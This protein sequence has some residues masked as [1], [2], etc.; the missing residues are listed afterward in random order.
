M[1]KQYGVLDPKRIDY[2][3][4][5]NLCLIAFGSLW[6]GI[7][8]ATTKTQLVAVEVLKI[9]LNA[10]TFNLMGANFLQILACSVL[11]YGGMALAV[12]LLVVSIVMKRYRAIP[13]NVAL[14]F[15]AGLVPAELAFM[16]AY[17]NVEMVG[18]SGVFAVVLGI[19]ALATLLLCHKVTSSSIKMLISKAYYDKCFK[20][21]H[22]Q[23]VE[24][25]EVVKVIEV[26]QEPKKEPKKAEEPK[27]EPKKAEEVKAEKSGFDV[28]SNHYTFAQKLRRAKPETRAKFK[29]IQKYLVSI[30]FR[31]KETKEGEIF[32]YKN[33]KYVHI[34]TAGQNGLKIY[35]KANP[36]DYKD[37]TIPFKDVSNK[38]KYEKT[39][40]LFTVKSDLAVK[41]A[42]KLAD[43]IRK[44]LDEE[45]K[46]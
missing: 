19:I 11:F 43:D 40:F 14:M 38:K 12:V 45:N 1:G 18:V 44:T 6:T 35:Y 42:K 39:P 34:T 13:G 15:T 8:I 24:V 36:K 27:K 4:A 2:F 26:P 9:L 20:E 16:F 46:K 29:D 30:G 37:S 32:T 7:W 41:R 25:V 22:E 21:H 33:V 5:L 3:F 23:P 10:L 17:A 28:N 31:D